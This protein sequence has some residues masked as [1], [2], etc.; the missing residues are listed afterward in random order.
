[1]F[2]SALRDLKTVFYLYKNRIL[3]LLALPIIFTLVNINNNFF[4][5]YMLMGSV[6]ILTIP[7]MEARDKVN[8]L[9]MSAPCRRKEMVAGRFITM[10]MWMAFIVVSG[11]IIQ[12]ILFSFIGDRIM[13]L[14]VGLIKIMPIA[15]VLLIG[16]SYSVYFI[17]DYKISKIW[18][19]ISFLGVM[20]INTFFNVSGYDNVYLLR[21]IINFVNSTAVINNV[22][23]VVI[24]A[25]I[26]GIMVVLSTVFY[27]KKDF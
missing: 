9:F 18:Y 2:K 27:E 3:I 6:M 17:F 20:M 4:S 8:I 26:L 5:L 16:L 12:Y 10:I 15:M 13:T 11:V 22:L 21:N 14:D 19:F 7:E 24:A 25:G 1:M 23:F